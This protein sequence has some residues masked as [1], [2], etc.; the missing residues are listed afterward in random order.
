MPRLR[1]AV[2]S[3]NFSE[4]RSNVGRTKG[5]YRQWQERR[6]LRSRM[7]S[8]STD[9]TLRKRSFVSF[10]GAFV[11]TSFGIDEPSAA[12]FYTAGKALVAFILF[13]ISE[14]LPVKK[15]VLHTSFSRRSAHVSRR[16][17]RD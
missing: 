1:Y 12:F 2:R 6:A 11:S 14:R 3:L 4:S 9:G 5:R 8:S 10:E 16:T 13:C 15:A 17:Y 7:T